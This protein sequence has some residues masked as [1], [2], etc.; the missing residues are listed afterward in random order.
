MIARTR[1]VSGTSSSGGMRIRSP[2]VSSACNSGTSPS[3][4][5][6]RPEKF[7][8][9]ESLQCRQAHD[10]AEQDANE[11]IKAVMHQTSGEFHF[12]CGHCSQAANKNERRTHYK[13]VPHL[14]RFGS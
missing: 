9:E 14:N 10:H 8:N 1:G 2:R 11:N 6:L 7:V 12:E 13:H 5:M 3:H 4:D